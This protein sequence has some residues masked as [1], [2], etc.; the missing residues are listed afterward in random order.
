[1]T[2]EDS[3]LAVAAPGLFRAGWTVERIRSVSRDRSAT[4]LSPDRIVLVESAGA[5]TGAGG[6]AAGYARLRPAVILAFHDLC[7]VQE[8]DEWHV[9]RLNTDGSVACWASY[10]S[11]LEAA[12]RA[13]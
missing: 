10:G 6:A 9:G 1:M 13:L 3:A 11:D 4:V 7:L 5:E 2:P 12:L 8:E